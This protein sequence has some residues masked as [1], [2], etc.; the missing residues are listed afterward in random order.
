MTQP[1]KF[2]QGLYGVTPEWDDPIRLEDAVRAASRGGMRALQ[3][4]HKT[5]DAALRLRLGAHLRDVCKELGVTF[6]IND[7]WQLAMEIQA[8]G[9]HL[10]Q[11]DE[12]PE[13]VRQK[14]DPDMLLGVSCYADLTRAQHMLTQ[15]VAYIAFG[16]MFG[17]AT[18]PLAPPAP[19]TVL[20]AGRAL[21][22]SQPAPR[23]A[24]V[25]I[26]GINSVNARQVYEAGADSIAVVGGLFLAS[27]IE[28]TARKLSSSFLIN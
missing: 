7:D 13:S 2:P 22:L 14:I 11:H 27:D 10:G 3:L 19:L 28:S 17:S 9:V 12:A 8:D 20:G 4:R 15:G 18:K 16:A 24:V 23:P 21:C 25:A 5:A 6:M 26:G 1:I